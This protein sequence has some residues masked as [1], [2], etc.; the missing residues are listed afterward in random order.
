MATLPK[1][2]TMTICGA[3]GN[4]DNDNIKINIQNLFKNINP[5]NRILYIEN[6]VGSK[7]VAAKQKK[8]RRKENTKMRKTF[9]NSVSLIYSI[10]SDK[11]INIK[12]FLNK[13]IQITGATSLEMGENAIQELLMYFTD[14]DMNFEKEECIFN[15]KD[16]HILNLRTVMKNMDFALGK[17]IDREK[18]YNELVKED[19][20]TKYEICSYPGV[21]IRYLGIDSLEKDGRCHCNN[22][23]CNC[24]SITFLVFQ[25]G[26]VLFIL[27]NHT[28][29]EQQYAYDWFIDFVKDKYIL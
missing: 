17:T 20:F 18:L 11:N 10:N 16:I 6:S 12:F 25:S 27:G 21:V 4:N 14:L 15:S 26:K 13:Q 7:G 1:I 5:N 28:E 23:E 8:K 19:I 3:I 29:E 22:F 9:M 2:S 24:R